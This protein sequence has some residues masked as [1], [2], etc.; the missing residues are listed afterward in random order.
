MDYE[1][2]LQKI[3]EYSINFEIKCLG[4]TNFG[5]KILAVERNLNKDF[6]TAIFVGG[7]HAREYITTDLLCRFLDEKVFDEIDSFNVSLILMANPDGVE[8]V[9]HGIESVPESS[10]K[11]VLEI[12]RNSCD[13]SMWK[14]NG[15][16]EDINNNF[17]SNFGT[18]FHSKN[19]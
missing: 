4:Y 19:P 13:F 1:T 17:D 2:L 18:N 7:M 12:N 14:A 15:I 3:N 10:R 16:G 5:R 9:K 11:K 6:A 8:L